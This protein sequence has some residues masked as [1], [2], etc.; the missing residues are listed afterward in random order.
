VRDR[1]IGIYFCFRTES[2]ATLC[3]FLR[4]VLTRSADKAACGKRLRRPVNF[5]S[6]A[7]KTGKSK[8]FPAVLMTATE[9]QERGSRWSRGMRRNR[10][11]R[12]VMRWVTKAD[13]GSDSCRL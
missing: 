11:H 1:V 5:N 8:Q 6:N 3:L 9:T 2:V 10:E 4:F 12:Y 7:E 13:N